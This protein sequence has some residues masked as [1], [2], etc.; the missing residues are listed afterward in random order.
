MNPHAP[1]PVS[2]RSLLLSI[3]VH[4]HLISQMTKREVIGR[5]K[6]SVMGILWSFASP[7]LLLVIYTLVFRWCSRRDGAL[8]SLAVKRVRDSTVHR[9][10]H[11]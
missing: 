6:G 11:S 4:R 2:L 10:D 3:W 5:Y 9:H 8:V 1:A 7:I